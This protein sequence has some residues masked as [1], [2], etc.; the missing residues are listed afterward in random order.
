M[1]ELKS[2]DEVFESRKV[3]QDKGKVALVALQCLAD[4]EKLSGEFYPALNAFMIEF[5][6]KFQLSK[7]LSEVQLYDV[8][9]FTKTTIENEKITEIDKIILEIKT[10]IQP[11]INKFVAQG[12]EP[13]LLYQHLGQLQLESDDDITILSHD[14]IKDIRSKISIFLNYILVKITQPLL[15]E[16]YFANYNDSLYL[17]IMI[18]EWANPF[19]DYLKKA[20]FKNMEIRDGDI[21]IRL[22]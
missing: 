6:E 20:K 11:Y 19:N 15:I 17:Y 9:T 14:D 4:E 21:Y 1:D 8:C 5:V 10:I 16:N 7:K 2:L 22:I 12:I 13:K 3:L 18:R